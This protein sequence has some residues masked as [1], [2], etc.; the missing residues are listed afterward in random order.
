MSSYA[1]AT[2]SVESIGQWADA[3]RQME[4]SQD[5]IRIVYPGLVPAVSCADMTDELSELP[6]SLPYS[7]LYKL[8]PVTRLPA[9]GEGPDRIMLLPIAVSQ[10]Q[11]IKGIING[12]IAPDRQK[13]AFTSLLG[14]LG[15]FAIGWHTDGIAKTENS[16]DISH[17]TLEGEV[18]ASFIP[19]ANP[20]RIGELS[21]DY[22]VE[23]SDKE[24]E[25]IETIALGAGDF[26]CFR[27]FS[28]RSHSGYV[29]LHNFESRYK[30]RS[31]VILTKTDASALKSFEQL[32]DRVP[33]LGRYHPEEVALKSAA[34][35]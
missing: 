20:E 8:L 26:I 17:I 29:D 27:G 5:P 3:Y 7:T 30:R 25:L 15:G 28:D 16:Q 14:N 1:A 18:D 31:H 22:A 4:A 9:L 35:L 23:L 13:Y 21:E 11:M 10:I 24:K 33:A 19:I 2:M 34:Y 12:S 6:E 32:V